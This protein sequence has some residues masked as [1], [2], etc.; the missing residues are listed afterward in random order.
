MVRALFGGGG[1][2]F[3]PPFCCLDFGT[4]WIFDPFY[5]HLGV[6]DVVGPCFRMYHYGL[7]CSLTPPSGLPNS[8]SS[9]RF[10]A[11]YAAFPGDFPV[12]PSVPPSPT[13]SSIRRS[14]RRRSLSLQLL[15]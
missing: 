6:D 7:R 8:S 5:S 2:F 9:P 13:K 11:L 15:R 12:F 10:Y 14:V 4:F 1:D 3:S